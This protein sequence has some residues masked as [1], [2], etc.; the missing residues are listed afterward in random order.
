MVPATGLEPVRCYSLEPESS[1][2][3]NS[4][5]RAA[6]QKGIY[7]EIAD[8]RKRPILNGRLWPRGFKK[9]ERARTPVRSSVKSRRITEFREIAESSSVAANWKVRAPF[10]NPASDVVMP[11][12]LRRLDLPDCQ[13]DT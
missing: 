12:P 7:A 2:S 4:A 13:P 3:A 5:T 11:R 1:A 6:L 10:W 9:A 8:D